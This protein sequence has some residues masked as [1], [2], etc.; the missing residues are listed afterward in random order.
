MLNRIILIVVVLATVSA[1]CGG[2][3]SEPVARFE[4]IAVSGPEIEVDPSGTVA[5]LT[6]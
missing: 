2:A 4:E 3:F 5:V 6:V 1:A